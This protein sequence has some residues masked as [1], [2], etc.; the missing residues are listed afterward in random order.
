MACYRDIFF[1]NL[2]SAYRPDYADVHTR[3]LG[4]LPE[5]SVATWIILLAVICGL[6]MLF[7]IA[8][9]LYKVKLH[10]CWALYSELYTTVRTGMKVNF[11]IADLCPLGD[12]FDVTGW[13]SVSVSTLRSRSNSLTPLGN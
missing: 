8:M 6:L 1:I 2:F 10:T 3:F 11:I 12:N 13:A 5:G 7:L 9:A 4:M